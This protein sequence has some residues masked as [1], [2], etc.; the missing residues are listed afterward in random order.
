MEVKRREF[1]M[2]ILYKSPSEGKRL[3]GLSLRLSV[4]LSVCLSLSGVGTLSS[5]HHQH[6]FS[7]FA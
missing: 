3:Y 2:W 1:G 7:R 6:H 4:S 5:N